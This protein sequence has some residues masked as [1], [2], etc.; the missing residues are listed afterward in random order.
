MFSDEI[1]LKNETSYF[2]IITFV[3]MQFIALLLQMLKINSIQ[4]KYKSLTEKVS[5][6]AHVTCKS[7]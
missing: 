3:S 1:Y 2:Y 5:I 7:I 6:I 4:R